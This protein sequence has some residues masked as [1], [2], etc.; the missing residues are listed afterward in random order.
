MAT[1]H[2]DALESLSRKELQKLC[3]AHGIKANK[4]NVELVASLRALGSSKDNNS[5]SPPDQVQK[6]EMMEPEQTVCGSDSV[7]FP[8][9]KQSPSTKGSKG[10]Q[11]K[12]RRKTSSSA[13]V[14]KRTTAKNERSQIHPSEQE[15]GTE[16]MCEGKLSPSQCSL[17]PEP[18]AITQTAFEK[19]ASSTSHMGVIKEMQCTQELASGNPDQLQDTSSSD[20]SQL[21]GAD[22]LSNEVDQ[23]D[24]DM[25][26]KEE[27]LQRMSDTSSK[28]MDMKVAESEV[29][30]LEGSYREEI[31]EGKISLHSV[32]VTNVAEVGHESTAL[33]SAGTSSRKRRRRSTFD[34]P[35]E[36]SQCIN[37]VRPEI[38]TTGDTASKGSD[39]PP[40]AKKGRRG[41]FEVQCE[42][43]DSD[44]GSN[45]E[46]PAKKVRVSNDTSDSKEVAIGDTDVV[47]A[48]TLKQD[49][50]RYLDKK[51]S[52]RS[53]EID[54]LP[55]KPLHHYNRS[56]KIPVPSKSGKNW[57]KIHRRQFARYIR[58]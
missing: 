41:T 2:C 31:Q 15:C 37:V 29:D 16:V 52:E 1:I 58:T 33:D 28:E 34:V 23:P 18:H 21:K 35:H 25:S 32:C 51:V 47:A 44:K 13:H 36:F 48:D 26:F 11:R 56:T 54:G 19:S 49:L 45:L 38:T 53:D 12:Q 9:Q 43:T 30:L 42:P 55:R 24:M 17:K 4:K 27:Y 22:T 39:L 10:K 57:D 6:T 5:D 50:L 14:R 3:K 46:P 7:K 8:C 20:P 40:P